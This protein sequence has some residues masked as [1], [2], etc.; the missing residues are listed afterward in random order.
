MGSDPNVEPNPYGAIGVVYV[1]VTGSVSVPGRSSPL[2]TFG[3]T[4]KVLSFQPYIDALN[5]VE[6]RG[7]GRRGASVG[8]V[9]GADRKS[10]V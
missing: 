7:R 2:S 4:S 6:V 1:N 5:D 9:W 3:M 8:A 10:V